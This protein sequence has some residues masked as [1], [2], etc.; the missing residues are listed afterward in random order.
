MR[1]RK[2]TNRKHYVCMLE[3]L[4]NV[5]LEVCFFNLYIFK[6]RRLALLLPM[7][8]FNFLFIHLF[9][10][11]FTF[12]SNNIRHHG[13]ADMS[14]CTG[15]CYIC[16]DTLRSIFT[17]ICARNRRNFCGPANWWDEFKAHTFLS[18]CSILIATGR[19]SGRKS[20]NR[21]SIRLFHV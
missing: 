7:S 18:K 17:T 4:Y 1:G 19:F 21:N 6:R 20:G 10:Q 9:I 14:L 16:C 11:P 5:A 3:E 2:S 15:I 12:R 13:L 8:D